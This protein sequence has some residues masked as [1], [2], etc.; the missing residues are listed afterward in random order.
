MIDEF[1]FVLFKELVMFY[2]GENCLDLYLNIF[3]LLK[4]KGLRFLLDFFCLKLIL[5]NEKKY[6]DIINR[7]PFLGKFTGLISKFRTHFAFTLK[8]KTD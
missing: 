6:F 7:N 1:I 2:L 8:I 3:M 5:A 4:R